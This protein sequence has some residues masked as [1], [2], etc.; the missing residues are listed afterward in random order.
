MTDDPR[1]FD[2]FAR[3]LDDEWRRERLRQAVP[4]P[5]GASVEAELLEAIDRADPL[6]ATGGWLSPLREAL[7]TWPARLLAAGVA[8]AC[9]VLGLVL[10][11]AT[12]ERQVAKGGI[13]P[14]PVETP[15]YTPGPR[16]ALG[17]GAPVRPESERKFLEAMAFYGAPDFAAK[18]APALREAV[19]LDRA[20]DQAQFWL[21]V[22][23]LLTDR[24]AA[25]VPPLEEAVKLAP[26]RARYKQY[27]VYAYLRTGDTARALRVQTEL[28][29]R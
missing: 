12:T 24:P 26:A 18:A 27:L 9:L 28:L 14:T 29:K 10:G 19:A 16:T 5:V 3:R 2:A 6:D 17:I 23:L 13:P 7:A 4:P 15:D 1:D 20:N 21:G 25:A 8:C 22:T 11:R